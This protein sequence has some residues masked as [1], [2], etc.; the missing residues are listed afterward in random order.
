MST[1]GYTR[2]TS[3]PMSGDTEILPLTN[4]DMI[5][6]GQPQRKAYFSKRDLL[7]VLGSCLCLAISF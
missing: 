4:P 5:A 2:I 3:S 1:K 7:A 6:L